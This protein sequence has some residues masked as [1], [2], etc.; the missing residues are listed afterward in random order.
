MKLELETVKAERGKWIHMPIKIY[1]FLKLQYL[2][3]HHRKHFKTE[4]IHAQ[5]SAS[6][7]PLKLGKVK[8]GV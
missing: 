4:L 1:F 5:A 7:L 3:W 8:V 6:V 2:L